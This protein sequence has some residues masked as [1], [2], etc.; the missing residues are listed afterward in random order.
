[1]FRLIAA[2][3]AAALALCA[4][5]DLDTEIKSLISAYATLETNA[6]DSVTAERAFYQ[7]AIPGLLRV[8]DPHSVFFDSGQFDQLKQMESSTQKGFGSVVSLIPGRVIVLQTLAGTPSAKAGLSAGDEILAVNGYVI[9]QLDTDQLTELLTE[10]R[11][12]PARLAVRRAGS[13]HILDLTLIPAAMESPSVERAFLLS[14]GVGYIRVSSFDE[15]TAQ[16]LREAIETLGG[17][18]LAGLVLDFRNNPGG[19]V[20][21]AL[22]TASL[23]LNPG[24]TIF[25]VRGRR[26]PEKTETVP[27]GA[28]PYGC[29]LAILI[30][31]KS[32][33]AAEIVTGAL[34]DHDRATVLG[35]P[36]YG[37][38]LVQSVYPMSQGTGLALTTALYYTPSGRSIQKPLDAARFE[39]AATTAHPNQ[40]KEFRTDG[41][42]V[43]TGGGGIQPDIVV[44]PPAMNRL[45]AVLEASAS[46]TVFATE[47]LRD[48]TVTEQ[49]AVTPELLNQFQEFLA[50]RNIQPG[51]SEWSQEGDFVTNRLKTEIFNQAFGV[52]KGDEVEAERDPA[53]QRARAVVG[54]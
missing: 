47:Y 53:I 4:A 33:S 48:H 18:R 50:A 29:K 15:H 17:N 44:A 42:R 19:M 3:F 7:G 36:S 8:L 14:A 27:A 12:R 35:E 20:T 52:A 41:G 38:G 24:Q 32:A 40:A 26:F 1:M 6:A 28:K 23:F 43:V 5:D 2:F 13:T 37:K 10:S 16:G 21:A 9:A 30:D 25:T 11:Q 54:P 51:V 49:F 22:E 45:R 34:Q 39:L 31:G 46:F